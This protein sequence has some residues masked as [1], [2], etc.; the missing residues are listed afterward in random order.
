VQKALQL[1]GG[2]IRSVK[3]VETQESTDQA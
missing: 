2:E 1:F 3:R